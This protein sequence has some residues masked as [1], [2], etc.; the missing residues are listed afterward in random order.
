MQIATKIATSSIS[1][2]ADRMA[3]PV[4]VRSL[5]VDN[6]PN[7]QMWVEELLCNFG[8]STALCCA[9][10]NELHKEFSGLENGPKLVILCTDKVS[11]RLLKQLE[12]FTAVYPLPVLMLAEDTSPASI[13]SALEAGVTGYMVVGVQGNRIKQAIETTL[14]QFDV[15][16]ELKAEIRSLQAQ[17]ND[18]IVIEKAKGLVMKSRGI[19][20]DEAYRY[21]RDYSMKKGIKL[22][23]VAEIILTTAEIFETSDSSG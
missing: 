22:A 3:L 7:R 18:R 10:L 17:L 2:I 19:S 4:G 8:Y 9:D 14:V 12:Q 20:E 16:T 15:I 1:N 23:R 11:E 5:I 13:R 6:D 21:L